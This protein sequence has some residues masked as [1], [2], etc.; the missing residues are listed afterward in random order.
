ME[1]RELLDKYDYPGDDT[2]IIF[3][4]ALS[5]LNGTNPELGKDRVK[6]L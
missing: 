4:S 6:E 1:I 5:A 2:H 3:G